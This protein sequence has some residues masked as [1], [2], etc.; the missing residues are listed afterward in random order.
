[1]GEDLDRLVRIAAVS[2]EIAVKVGAEKVR[3]RI[4][5]LQQL[6]VGVDEGN[7]YPPSR[8]PLGDRERRAGGASATERRGAEGKAKEREVEAE[9][10]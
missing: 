5:L 8:A 6:K 9:R 10:R 1:M 4:S 7:R 3:P 2:H